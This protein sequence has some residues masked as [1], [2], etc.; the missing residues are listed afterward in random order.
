MD[1]YIDKTMYICLY[2]NSFGSLLLKILGSPG[3]L[4]DLF[5]DLGPLFMFWV[6]FS[7]C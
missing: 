3:P 7:L 4:G 2:M 6:P 1:I 5:G